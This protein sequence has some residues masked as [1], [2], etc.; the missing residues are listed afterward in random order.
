MTEA[1]DKHHANFPKGLIA[2]HQKEGN[3]GSVGGT[4]LYSI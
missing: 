3:E 4:W 1:D 2:K